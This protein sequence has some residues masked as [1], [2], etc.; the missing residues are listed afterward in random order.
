MH[1]QA[2]YVRP[3]LLGLV[4]HLHVIYLCM[5]LHE[6]CLRAWVSKKPI[7]LQQ[8]SHC[9]PE[10]QWGR[11]RGGTPDKAC[12]LASGAAGAG[13]L[14]GPGHHRP[15]LLGNAGACVAPQFTAGVERLESEGMAV[16][17]RPPRSPVVSPVWTRRRRCPGGA[18][19]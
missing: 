14:P 5:A 12:A 2:V 6:A 4:L 11:T 15:G 9:L 16:A 13:R 8:D 17:S 10:L 3:T 19:L 18:A 1:K 7:A